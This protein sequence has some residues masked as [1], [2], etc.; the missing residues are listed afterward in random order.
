VRRRR[1]AASP[2]GAQARVRGVVGGSGC[3]R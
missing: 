1:V 3:E 2:G